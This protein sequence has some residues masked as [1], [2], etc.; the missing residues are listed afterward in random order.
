MSRL[1][2]VLPIAPP[3]KIPS[4]VTVGDFILPAGTFSSLMTFYGFLKIYFLGS[5]VQINLYSLHR[6]KEIWI[7]PENFRPERFLEDG[8]VVQVVGRSFIFGIFFCFILERMAPTFLLWKKKMY[9]R[10]RC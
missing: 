6:K 1:A 7:D 3:R 2:S 9:W 10:A 5:M 8:A 4:D